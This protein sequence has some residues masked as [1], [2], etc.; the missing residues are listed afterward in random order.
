M[1]TNATNTVTATFKCDHC[2]WKVVGTD[3][4]SVLKAQ[5]AAYDCWFATG[6]D[7]NPARNEWLCPDHADAAHGATGW[8]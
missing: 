5:Q 8:R 7:F 1:S 3:R 4:R 2:G 6:G